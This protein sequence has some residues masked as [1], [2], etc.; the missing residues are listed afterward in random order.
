[1]TFE[2]HTTLTDPRSWQ[3]FRRYWRPAAPFVGLPARAVL[4]SVKQ[5]ADRTR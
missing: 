4:R 1:M 3:R 5:D 2:T